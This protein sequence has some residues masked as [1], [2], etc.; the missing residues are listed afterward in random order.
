VTKLVDKL[1]EHGLVLRERPLE[2]GRVVLVSISTP[3]R[4]KI[5]AARAPVRVLMRETLEDLS[6]VELGDLVAAS[7]ALGR[8]IE[9]LQR[10]RSKT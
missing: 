8:L 10:R 6:T 1:Q 3:G 5:E 2:E 9:T 4:E 7:E